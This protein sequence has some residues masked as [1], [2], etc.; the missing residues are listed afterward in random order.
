M[1]LGLSKNNPI[2]NTNKEM[3]NTVYYVIDQSNLKEST[4]LVNFPV[5]V[6]SVCRFC[7]QC[8]HTGVNNTADKDSRDVLLFCQRAHFPEEVVTSEC[9]SSTRSLEALLS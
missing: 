2:V 1:L 4:R 8:Q 3:K 6:G 9:V 5:L 7:Y